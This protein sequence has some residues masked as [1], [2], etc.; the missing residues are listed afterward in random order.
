MPIIITNPRLHDN[1]IVFANDAFLALTG[2]DRD[3]IIGRNCRFLQV[4]ET[5]REDVARVRTA[6]ADRTPIELDLLNYRKDG[7]TFWN[8]LLISPVFGDGGELTY[9]FACQSD[10]TH[11]REDRAS[12]ER[13]RSASEMAAAGSDADL[14]ACGQQL[15]LALRAGRLGAWSR[16]LVTGQM[17]VSESCK[18]YF[19]RPLHAPFTYEELTASIHP[20]DRESRDEALA[21]AIANGTAYDVEYRILTPRGEERWLNVRG[22][23]IYS[24]DGAPLSLV[25][26][27]Q[28][29]TARRRAEDHRALLANELSHRV[30][31]SL[32]VIQA[33]IAQTLRKAGS[34][35]EAGLTLEARIQALAWANDLLVNERWE[36]ASIHGL[37]HR[38]LA[39]FGIEDAGQFLLAGP[40]VRLPPRIAAA[41]ALALHE[42]ATNASKYGAL[43]RSGGSVRLTWELV[44]GLGH[45]R[46]RF[47]WTEKDGPPVTSPTRS[48]FGTRLIQLVLA[49]EIGGE[50]EIA[51]PRE[52]VAFA[53]VVPLADAPVDQGPH[54]AGS[55]RTAGSRAVFER[56]EPVAHTLSG[57]RTAASVN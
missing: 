18:E 49:Q 32:T 11:E 26:V 57:E 34:L 27:T 35:K 5:S 7:T 4:P 25:G 15:R 19:G 38:T 14:Q 16:D 37:I 29:V 48:G 47:T 41:L 30:K 33:V 20:D 55:E 56:A 24:A 10:V 43:S 46:L 28:D 50:V 51:Y 12:L 54:S 22:Q 9:S 13:D 52:G 3:E 17:I 6:V 40:D 21:S 31:N 53:A 45:N 44:E 42:L 1:Q 2:F 39:A 8:R 36:N 23:A